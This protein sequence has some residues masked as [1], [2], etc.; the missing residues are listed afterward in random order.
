[1]VLAFPAAHYSD[2]E[3]IS[4]PCPDDQQ[5]R[6][7]KGLLKSL[8]NHFQCASVSLFC[9]SCALE[10]EELK[11]SVLNDHSAVFENGK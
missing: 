5:P 2:I 6:P 11:T 8:E 1:M 10:E 3:T 7:C 9:N 4:S